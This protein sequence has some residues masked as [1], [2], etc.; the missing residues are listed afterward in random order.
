[1]GDFI[2]TIAL[3]WTGK[4]RSWLKQNNDDRYYSIFSETQCCKLFKL[5]LSRHTL[6]GILLQYTYGHLRPELD[7]IDD[8]RYQQPCELFT[9]DACESD[10]PHPLGYQ[11]EKRK[12][13]I[14]ISTLRVMEKNCYMLANVKYLEK[15]GESYS[16]TFQQHLGG[17][18]IARNMLLS[19]RKGNIMYPIIA[20]DV[21]TESKPD[22]VRL[23]IVNGV[24]DTHEMPIDE[25][26]WKSP[27]T[28]NQFDLRNFRIEVCLTYLI[29]FTYLRYFIVLFCFYIVMSRS[30]TYNNSITK[31]RSI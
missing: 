4:L 11:M 2:T 22:N 31:E 5:L 1:M 21:A 16:K 7:K 15:A 12:N 8:I 30:S 13:R 3:R 19:K 17:N 26:T 25:P 28:G 27:E 10:I 24:M 18:I 20:T 14:K 23:A 9:F 29:F 6:R